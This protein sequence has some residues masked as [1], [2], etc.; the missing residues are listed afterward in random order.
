MQ[1]YSRSMANYSAQQAK[2]PEEM[3]TARRYERNSE[4]SDLVIKKLT[5]DVLDELKMVVSDDTRL[6]SRQWDN[7]E[8]RKYSRVFNGSIQS[9]ACLVVRPAQT[10]DVSEYAPSFFH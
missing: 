5:A 9:P 10:K 1:S 7:S 6:I 2:E 3:A 8:F 4:K